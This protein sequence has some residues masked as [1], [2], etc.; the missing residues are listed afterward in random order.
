MKTKLVLSLLVVLIP[1]IISAQTYF[2]NGDATFMGNDCYRLTDAFNDENGTVWYADQID[3]SQP[4]ELQFIMNFGT[5]DQNGADGIVFVLQTEGTD[6][7][8]ITGG[9][10]GFE[11]FNNSFGIEFD[12]WSNA[13][14]GDPLFDHIA[15]V[16]DGVVNHNAPQNIAGPVQASNLSVNIED[17]QNHVVTVRWNPEALTISVDFDCQPRLTGGIDLV[18]E[19][20]NGQESVY[21][22]FTASTGGA[23]NVQT[24]CLQ[25]NIV[26]SDPVSFICPGM[27]VQ[28]SASGNANGTFTWT[29][30][31]FLDNP[32]IPNPVATP[33]VTTV[34]TVSY[35][36]LCGDIVSSEYTITVEPLTID[37]VA[38]GILNCEN[39][40]VDLSFESSFDGLD[41][42][43]TTPG[44]ATLDNNEINVSNSGWYIIEGALDAFCFD[45]DSIFI[46]QNF[47]VYDVNLSS[48]GNIDCIQNSVLITAEAN[49]NANLVWSSADIF[50]N[51]DQNNIIEAIEGGDFTVTSIHPESACESEATI[52]VANL[53][54]YPTAE[55][56]MNDSLSCRF[57]LV[58]IEGA[59]V[60]PENI[61]IAWTSA[62]GSSISNS[63]TLS[64]TVSEAGVYYLTATN[65][66]N[67]CAS[68]DSVF[69]FVDE[70]FNF[71]VDLIRFPNI[72]TPNG[73]GD[74]EIFRPY[75]DGDTEFN[76][77]PLMTN[78]ELLIYNRW[79][80]IVAEINSARGWD[81]K[82]SGDDMPEGV[83]YYI[84]R[85]NIDCNTTTPF[86]VNG[87]LQILR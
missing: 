49:P 65:P 87:A 52:N 27:D 20:F 18:N 16:S 50:I 63:N 84:Y 24:V 11:G 74:N 40:T 48:T 36:D 14:N 30:T 77:F 82:D 86:D 26:A 66:I 43:W 22:G 67:N 28:L 46:D 56:G 23:V 13:D 73:D 29:P 71:D 51:T 83:Y 60:F 37:P 2:L 25:D 80:Q 39:E 44:G 6:A 8:G 61:D 69:V 85:F 32:N 68:T 81:G 78:V 1:T 7:L 54:S 31:D 33:P 21:F 62:N 41:I 3:L 75:L 55:A 72:I 35:E 4:F 34:Y 47:E 57:P 12:T 9:G 17:G 59:S 19:I 38:S 70:N 15:M 45:E 5:F 58:Q 64:P 10:L 79:G 42:Q 76:L 53:I